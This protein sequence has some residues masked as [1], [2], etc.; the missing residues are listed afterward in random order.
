M[1]SFA[2]QTGISRPAASTEELPDSWEQ[3][4]QK[5]SLHYMTP[6]NACHEAICKSLATPMFATFGHAAVSVCRPRP[7]Q[8]KGASKPQTRKGTIMSV[9]K[10]LAD[11][12]HISDP[13][14]DSHMAL[15]SVFSEFCCT[16]TQ[17][18]GH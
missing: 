11:K 3:A 9:R 8:L 4:V 14:D 16:A 7:P 5:L 13:C 2:I 1:E 17:A 15:A 18:Q 12:K 6:G 10:K